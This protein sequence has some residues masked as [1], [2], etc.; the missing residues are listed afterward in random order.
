MQDFYDSQHKAAAAKQ[1]EREL[2]RKSSAASLKSH[3]KQAAALPAGGGSIQDIA[4][5]ARAKAQD[6]IKRNQHG[7]RWG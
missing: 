1:A 4:A 2:Q 3:P 6:V 5:A 7:S